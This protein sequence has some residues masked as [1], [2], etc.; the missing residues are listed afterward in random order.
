M[1]Y[2]VM[3]KCTYAVRDVQIKMNS[4][5]YGRIFPPSLPS[6]C[7]F[8]NELLYLGWP[9]SPCGAEDNLEVLILQLPPL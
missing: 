3:F 1:S 9:Q 7:F 4:S 2:N 5:I 6:F 8:S